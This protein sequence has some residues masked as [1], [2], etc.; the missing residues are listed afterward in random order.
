ML[1]LHSMGHFNPE[2]IL[3]N[4]F[5]EDLDIGTTNEWIMERVGAG[6]TWAY[7]M[8]KVESER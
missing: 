1:Y 7:M 2:N 6:L 4:K 3:S 5:L 8:L